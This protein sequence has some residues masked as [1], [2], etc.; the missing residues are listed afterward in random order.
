MSLDA[1]DINTVYHAVLLYNRLRQGD[2]LVKRAMTAVA[3]PDSS[4]ATQGVP[5]RLC[6]LASTGGSRCCRAT[7]AMLLQEEQQGMPWQM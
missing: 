2:L 3:T 1:C 4:V 6:T 5:K 7:A